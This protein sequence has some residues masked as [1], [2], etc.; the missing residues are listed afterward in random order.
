MPR[1]AR[2]RSRCLAI[3][4]ALGS[5]TRRR[6]TATPSTWS[7]PSAIAVRPRRSNGRGDGSAAT[8]A[9]APA[10]NAGDSDDEGRRIEKAL[11]IWD[12]A[13]DPRRTLVETY[14][15]GRALKLTDALANKVI[16]FHRRCPWRDEAGRSLRVPAMVVAMRSIATDEITAIQRTRLSSEGKKIERRMLGVA[17][18]AAVKLDA[19]ERITKRLIIGEGVET[20]MTAQ[21]IGLT[22]TWA[23]GS[24]G[25]IAAFPVLDEIA[26]LMILAE[27]DEANARD[28]ETCAT[29]WYEAGRDVVINHPTSGND[30]NDALQSMQ[31]ARRL[32]SGRRGAS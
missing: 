22:P 17:G 18:G 29:R 23:L 26:R 15:R 2:W 16:R 9:G 28:T 11:A 12:E 14:L 6:S 31:R 5:I 24:A 30:L 1:E 7:R 25:A 4:K 13:I 21:Q 8:A 10:P 19:D 27:N 20:A 32:A 3:I